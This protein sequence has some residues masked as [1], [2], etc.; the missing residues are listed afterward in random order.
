MTRSSAG[1]EGSAEGH[2]KT[3][4]ATAVTETRPATAAISMAGRRRL[5]GESGPA[6]FS[7]SSELDAFFLSFFHFFL[8]F[9][10]FFGD[11]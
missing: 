3:R 11:S 6:I 4:H 1:A 10:L 2:T 9:F 8:F 5:S 7:D